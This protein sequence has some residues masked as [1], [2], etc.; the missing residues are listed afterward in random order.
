MTLLAW[1]RAAPEQA[2]STRSF[3]EM[4]EPLLPGWR[5]FLPM[6]RTWCRR[7]I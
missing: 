2:E 6:P 1:K 3:E 4:A 5:A 7:H